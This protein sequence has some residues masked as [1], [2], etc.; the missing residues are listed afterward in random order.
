[1]L[2]TLLRRSSDDLTRLARMYVVTG[3]PLFEKQFH[4]VL[5][6]RNGQS[7]LP[8][9]YDRVY[10]DFMAVSNDL[11]PF[12]LGKPVSLISLM[13][14]ANFTKSEFL[15][16]EKSQDK[17]DKLVSIEETSFNAINGIFQDEN[18]EFTISAKPNKQMAIDLL[19]SDEYH[20]AKINIMKPINQFYEALDQRTK[21]KVSD[22]ANRLNSSSNI[23]IIIFILSVCAI[24]LLIFILWRNHKKMLQVLNQ[25]VI[26]RTEE[27][28]TSNIELKNSLEQIKTLEGIITVCA[29]CHNI[30]DDEMEWNTMEKYFSDHSDAR[31]SHGICPKCVPIIRLESG[32]GVKK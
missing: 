7:P 11:T 14:S 27:L 10:W 13:K 19:H 28:Q 16:L 22:T 9:N 21:K 32:L 31:F 3:N 2:T 1:M 5:A 17:S 4:D 8:V 23:Q 20:M 29:Y 24:A 6:I 15:L 12:E 25:I 26:E 18:G 30:R